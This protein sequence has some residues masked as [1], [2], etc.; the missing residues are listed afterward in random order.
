[1][2]ARPPL[3]SI[4]SKG[5]PSRGFALRMDSSIARGLG[6]ASTFALILLFSKSCIGQVVDPVTMAQ[7]PVP[8]VG[9]HYIGMG[10]ETVNPA[11]GSVS[12]D[13]PIQTPPGRGLSFP[14]G[15]H[16][17]EGEPFYLT[18]AN[19]GSS[20]GWTTPAASGQLSPFDLNGWSYQLPNY[21]AQAFLANTQT[22][23]S[24]CSSYPN[25]PVNY[26]W[27]TQNYSFSG[28][29]GH[30]RIEGLRLTNPIVAQTRQRRSYMLLAI[31]SVHEFGR[32]S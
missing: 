15:I 1:M 25:C 7:A 8:G 27:G 32:V 14:F 13:L 22:E 10:T 3:T 17:S 30:I 24:G 9:H 4:P 26:C 21:Q 23:S 16:Y 5:A 11:D 12:F 20:F 6:L 2:I 18:N 19:Y 29:D 28:F 31:T